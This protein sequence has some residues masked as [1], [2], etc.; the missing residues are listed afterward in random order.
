VRGLFRGKG[1][2]HWSR[3][4]QRIHEDVCARLARDPDVDASDIEV[5]V[6]NF[7]VTLSGTVADRRMKVVAED[8]I[9]GAFGVKDVHNRL[10]VG[11]GRR[12]R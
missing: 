9:E 7:E 5:T 4:E 1:L 3:A 10:T 8:A 11:R 12:R 2:K 6:E